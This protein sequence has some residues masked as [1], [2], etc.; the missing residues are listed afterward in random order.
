M[1]PS[2]SSAGGA[3]DIAIQIWSPILEH[4]SADYRNARTEVLYTL[5]NGTTH[6]QVQGYKK[7]LDRCMRERSRARR[8]R[9]KE[10]KNLPFA[11]LEVYKDGMR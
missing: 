9:E 6:E 11:P 5:P 8:E 2:Y 7:F 4:S 1:F 10:S 3:Y